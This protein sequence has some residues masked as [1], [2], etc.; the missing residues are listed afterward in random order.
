MSAVNVP[1]S[2]YASVVECCFQCH[3]IIVAR[4]RGRPKKVAAEVDE[5]GDA[6]ETITISLDDLID[7]PEAASPQ[8]KRKTPAKPISAK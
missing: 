5:S 6:P 1:L 3:V 4:R 7:I 2:C 8:R